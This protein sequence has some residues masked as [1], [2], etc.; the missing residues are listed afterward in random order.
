MSPFSKLIEDPRLTTWEWIAATD[1]LRWTSG[2]KEIYSRPAEEINS[3]AAWYQLIHPDDRERVRH[4][5]ERALEWGTGFRERFRLIGKRGEIYWILGHARVFRDALD[6]LHLLGLN[7]DVTD[8]VDALAASEARFSATFEQAAVGI[9]HVGLEGAW[10]NVNQRCLDILG[11][12][13]EELLKLTFAD[14]THP[15]DLASDWAQVHEL[16]RG[17]RLT[18]SMEK[19]YFAKDGRLIWTNLTV[20]LVRK[21]DGSPDYFISVIED[22]TARKRLEAERDDLIEALEKR[23]RE[24]TAELE[25]LTLTD[26]LTGIANRRCLDDRLEIE[27]KRAIRTRQ[28]LSVLLIDVDHFKN[29]NDGF[30][31][32]T[33]DRALVSIASGLGNLARRASDM[34]ARYGGDEF[35]IV[36]PET[37]MDGAEIVARQVHEMVHAIGLR[38][39]ESAGMVNVTVS[40]GVA[41]VW[42]DNS[43][44]CWTVLSNADRALYFA[45]QSGRDRFAVFGRTMEDG[46]GAMPQPKAPP[47]KRRD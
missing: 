4:A 10:L 19:R 35:V 12:P 20:S 37:G 36:L 44:T 1:Q 9:A 11:Y 5:T 21:R 26:P 30:G 38:T 28:P 45:K 14:I 23:V 15:D 29:L 39:S 6:S 31:H 18:Y 42:P 46:K 25:K 40:Q 22:I 27:W 41:T 17:E 24:R 7:V 2:Q 34:A 43:A 16:I 13:K 8:W 47:A 32:A 33:A 3:T